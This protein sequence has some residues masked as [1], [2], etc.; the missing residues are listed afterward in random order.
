MNQIYTVIGDP[1]LTLKSYDKINKLFDVAEEMGN[2]IIFLGDFLDTKEVIRGKCLNLLNKRLSESKCGGVLIIGNHDYFNL[3]CE[4]HSLEVFK[5]MQPMWT[6]I[7]KPIKWNGMHFLPYYHDM[8]KLNGALSNIPNDAII[9]GHFDMVGFD[10]GNGYISE[11]GGS[12]RDFGR[13]RRVLSG[14]YHKFQQEANFTYLGTPFSHSFGEANQPKYI[15]TYDPVSDEL[16]LIPTEFERH[17][18]FEINCDKSPSAPLLNKKN[19]N[20]VVLTGKQE[21]IDDFEVSMLPEGTKVVERPTLEDN[22][23]TIEETCDNMSQFTIWAKE[24]KELDEE[25][26][27]IGIKILESVK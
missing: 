16:K 7:D 1:H 12:I 23:F 18:S 8:E 14:H 19:H 20:R 2:P 24:V 17:L 27:D 11:G 3:D 22:Q 15:G 10:Y 9:F 4:D 21:N 6:I 26:V 25:T 13:F 5:H